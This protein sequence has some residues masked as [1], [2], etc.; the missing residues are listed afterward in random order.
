MQLIRMTDVTLHVIRLGCP[1]MLTVSGGRFR[2]V[3]LLRH[4]PGLFY[5][6]FS[7][8]DTA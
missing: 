1:P 3:R 8:D 6:N 4:K 2:E 5:S 7:L